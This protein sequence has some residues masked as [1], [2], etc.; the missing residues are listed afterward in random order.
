MLFWAYEIL[1]DG[2]RDCR[3]HPTPGKTVSQE[4][5]DA[6]ERHRHQDEMERISSIQLSSRNMRNGN[7]W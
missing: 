6:K 7:K 4:M 2:Q 3:L 5:A 1:T